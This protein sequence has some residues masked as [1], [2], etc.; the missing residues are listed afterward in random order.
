MGDG[1]QVELLVVVLAAAVLMVTGARDLTVEETAAMILGLTLST[2]DA[3]E[4]ACLIIDVSAAAMA[5]VTAAM[6]LGFP[7]STSDAEEEASLMIDVTAA[8]TLDLTV[9]IGAATEA[10]TA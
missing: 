3:E 9:S 1:I 6:T 7:L 4:E 10:D 8:A 5:E 2:G